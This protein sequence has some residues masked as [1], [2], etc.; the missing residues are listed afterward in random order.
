MT[1]NKYWQIFGVFG[2]LARD[3][4]SKRQITGSPQQ[5]PLFGESQAW[6]QILSTGGV[7]VGHGELWFLTMSVLPVWSAGPTVVIITSA[8]MRG[9]LTL[10]IP[11][12]G[13]GGSSFSRKG[14]FPTPNIRSRGGCPFYTHFLRHCCWWL[15]YFY[16]LC[17]FWPGW[18]EAED[19]CWGVGDHRYIFWSRPTPGVSFRLGTSLMT[20]VPLGGWSQDFYILVQHSPKGVCMEG[21]YIYK[22]FATN[23]Q[24]CQ[25]FRIDFRLMA[26]CGSQLLFYFQTFWSY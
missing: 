21:L 10:S 17:H 4:T 22:K 19:V 15:N 9:V 1:N 12:E 26:I 6:Y 20:G 14:K 3:S 25:N 24:K 16:T 2:H 13:G 5:S 7:A 8:R 23:T 18:I 11:W